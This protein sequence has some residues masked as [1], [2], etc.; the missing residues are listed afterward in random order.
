MDELATGGVTKD[1][2]RVSGSSK[3]CPKYTPC[4]ACLPSM[5]KSTS[6]LP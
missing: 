1:K 6:E 5:K 3:N 4:N 2:I